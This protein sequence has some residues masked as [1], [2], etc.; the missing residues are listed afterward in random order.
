MPPGALLGGRTG[1]TMRSGRSARPPGA[2]PGRR[3]RR[4]RAARPPPR[5]RPQSSPRPERPC[6][7]WPTPTSP[8][9]RSRSASAALRTMSSGQVPRPGPSPRAGARA[10][11]AGAPAPARRR[12]ACRRPCRRSSPWPRC[13]AW[14]VTSPAATTATSAV[15]TSRIS[16]DRNSRLPMAPPVVGWSHCR[17]GR[18]GQPVQNP[19]PGGAKSG[20]HWRAGEWWG[21][22]HPDWRSGLLSS[23]RPLATSVVV[24]TMTALSPT[25]TTIRE[26]ALAPDLTRGALLLFIAI[27]ERRQRGLRR[28]ARRRRDPA[29]PRAG[30]QPVPAR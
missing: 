9:R 23:D 1:Q 12:R 22:A 13:W 16:P 5:R 25:P 18:D 17:R 21:F 26:R 4:P 20:P 3:A 8:A 15:R 2:S 30:R 19:D 29:R 14:L 11:V 27:A 6:A 24:M 7:T 28:P 10:R